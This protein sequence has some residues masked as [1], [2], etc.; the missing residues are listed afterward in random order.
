MNLVVKVPDDL[1]ERLCSFPFLQALVK[2]LRKKIEKENEE[3]PEEEMRSL[4]VHL[5]CLKDG[6]EALNL[7]PFKSFYHE[8][9]EEDLKTVFTGHRAV[10]NMKI[11]KADLFISLTEGF[12][13]ASLG[14]SMGAKERI[15]LNIGKNSLFFTK[16]SPALKGRHHAERL[17]GILPLVL[18]DSPETP[19]KG[20]S[21]DIEPIWEDWSERPYTVINLPAKDHEVKGQYDELFDLI[22]DEK[23]VFLTEGE[24]NLLV[25]NDWTK[26]LPTKN[27]YVVFE[28]G[29]LIKFSKLVSHAQLFISED[30]SLVN[31]A[32]YSGAH[33]YYLRKKDPIS[34]SG[35]LYFLGDVRYFDLNE[36]QYKEGA[37]TAYS[38]IFDE[39]L[40]Y[41]SN[42]KSLR[43]D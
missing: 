21:R 26:R 10:K 3:L 20:Y 14:K 40:A 39:V 22:E 41:L 25:V 8:V 24:E 33:I 34:K 6:I 43:G 4:S 35:P 16:K 5:I 36:P 1:R 29:D 19:Q 7:L 9:D 17:H 15:G 13:D 2:G 27:E 32:A 28:V 11:E 38:K 30:S 31:V 42:K 37:E 12:V 23:F 18:E